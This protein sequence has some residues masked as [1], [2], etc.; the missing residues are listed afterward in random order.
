MVYKAEN[1]SDTFKPFVVRQ[2]VFDTSKIDLL[3]KELTKEEKEIFY[4]DV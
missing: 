2:F 3:S 1:V 4:V